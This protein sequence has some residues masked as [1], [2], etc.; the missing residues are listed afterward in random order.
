MHTLSTDEGRFTI[1]T[2]SVDEDVPDSSM[3]G[4]IVANGGSCL[5]LL[6]FARHLEIL[7]LL[8]V[9]FSGKLWVLLEGYD[10]HDWRAVVFCYLRV[11]DESRGKLCG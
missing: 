3:S 1:L 9:R 5:I 11:E 6:A 8:K 4:C 10:Y 7:V 2:G